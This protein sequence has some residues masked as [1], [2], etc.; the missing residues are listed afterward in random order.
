MI[1]EGIG[2]VLQKGL[3]MNE[4]IK[5]W[6]TSGACLVIEFFTTRHINCLDTK[7]KDIELMYEI[8]KD[9]KIAL[10]EYAKINK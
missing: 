8:A 7:D 4:F 10:H 5:K 6:G 2:L 1:W 9:L 3:I